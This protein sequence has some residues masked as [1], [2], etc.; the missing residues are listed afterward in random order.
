MG[1]RAVFYTVHGG[2]SGSASDEDFGLHSPQEEEYQVVDEMDP[3]MEENP[4]NIVE[5]DPE[6]PL[7]SD[8]ETSSEEIS[9]PMVGMGKKETITF[10]DGE[11][12]RAFRGAIYCR[13]IIPQE[14]TINLP[15]V[16]EAL[17]PVLDSDFRKLLEEHH[18]LKGWVAL[19][20]LYKKGVSD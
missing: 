4:H 13:T 20:V 7:A 1:R 2:E 12:H 14:N 3:S 16:L 8:D 11:C 9:S 10:R 19:K 17:K 6:S 18:G 5:E 15:A